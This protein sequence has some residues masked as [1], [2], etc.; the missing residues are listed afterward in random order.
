[1][2]A[3]NWILCKLVDQIKIKSHFINWHTTRTA[4]TWVWY[5]IIWDVYVYLMYVYIYI[6]ITNKNLL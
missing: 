5:C 1:V 6:C 2:D 3:V 4:F